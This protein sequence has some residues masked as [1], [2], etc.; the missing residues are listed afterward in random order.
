MASLAVRTAAE[1]GAVVT[2]ANRT[3]TRAQRLAAAVG[4]AAV[5]LSALPTALR[6]TD[7]LVTCTGA[8]AVAITSADLADTR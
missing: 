1:A 8:R 3:L 7:V 2:C 5:E 4:G 6:N